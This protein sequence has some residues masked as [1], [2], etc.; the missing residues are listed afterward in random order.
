M[1][2]SGLRGA[3]HVDDAP[4]GGSMVHADVTVPGRVADDQ[5][6]RNLLAETMRHPQRDV[7]DNFNAG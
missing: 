6:V 2:I 4:A 7:S 3:A 5:Q 1:D